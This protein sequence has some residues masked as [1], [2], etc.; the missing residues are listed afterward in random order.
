MGKGPENSLRRLN[1]NSQNL[2]SLDLLMLLNST[3][4][5]GTTE[6]FYPTK[7]LVV[8]A[9]FK[10]THQKLKRNGTYSL[11]SKFK[12]TMSYKMQ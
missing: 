8:F 2:K 9:K 1:Y 12:V 4:N 5:W 3:G 7:S 11:R 10:E 6:A